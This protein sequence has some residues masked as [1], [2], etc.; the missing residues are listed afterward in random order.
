MFNEIKKH[1]KMN[2]KVVSLQYGVGKI[3]GNFNMYDGVDD[4]LE[5][6]YSDD[7]ETRYF[8]TKHVGDVRLLSSKTDIAFALKTMSERLNNFSIE[9]NFSRDTTK[10]LDKNVL[11]IV[12][13]IV[14]L[15]RRTTLN[16]INNIVLNESIDSLVH[17]V[18]E[19]YGVDHNCARGI[20]G[21]YLKCA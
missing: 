21:D 2:S 6:E 5:I 8:C 17:E 9:N 7:G 3:I 1:I 16:G 11:Y 19:V 18:E 20:V 12:L 14:E 15:F 4:Y 13:R 10:F